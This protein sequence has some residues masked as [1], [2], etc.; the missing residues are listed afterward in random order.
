MCVC[1]QCLCYVGG[2]AQLVSM[3]QEDNAVIPGSWI[4][5]TCCVRGI[6]LNQFLLRRCIQGVLQVRH[7]RYHA[8]IYNTGMSVC[9]RAGTCD[10][11]WY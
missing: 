8:Y 7:L 4:T 6:V 5:G 11:C 3:W 10:C 1:V 9:K 2:S